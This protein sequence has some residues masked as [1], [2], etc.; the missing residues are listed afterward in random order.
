MFSSHADVTL[1]SASASMK[2]LCRHFSHKVEAEFDDEN[3]RVL[4][5]FARVDFRADGQK[6]SIRVESDDEPGLERGREV[7]G[8]HLIRFA[9]RQEVELNWE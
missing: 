3:G 5:P 4:F 7:V 6:L 8:G 9:T 2:K 1:V